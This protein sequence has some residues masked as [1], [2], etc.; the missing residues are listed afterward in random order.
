MAMATAMAAESAATPTEATSAA[1]QPGSA[2]MSPYQDSE[3]PSGGNS[4]VFL[5]FTEM[6]AT[7]TRGA[8]R[9][10]AISAM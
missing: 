2:K 8:R 4:R 7:T 1:R 3:K 10:R 9:K 5:A 6:P